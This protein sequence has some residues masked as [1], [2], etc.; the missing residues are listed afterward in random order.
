MYAKIIKPILVISY[1]TIMSLILSLPRFRVFINIKKIFLCLMGA[2]I[3]VGVIIY[4]GVWIVPGRNLILED[5][6]SL[7]KGVLISSE[8]GV[9]IGKRTLIGYGT[10]IFSSN[11]SIPP[12][13]ERFPISGDNH[14]E[15]IIENDVWIGA[16]CIITAGVKIGE[17][18]VIA[19]GSVVT[20]N[21][22]KN[23]IA[24]GVPCKPIGKR[25][26]NLNI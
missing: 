15:V 1:E 10:K 7:A 18:A 24:A 21:I 23:I 4:P 20:K 12:A 5:E 16:N 26:K 22:N 14:D 19:A 8:G 2:K 17:G 3:G 25:T 6:V 11:H 13:G 9:K